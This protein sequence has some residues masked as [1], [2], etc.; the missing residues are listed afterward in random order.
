MGV[1]NGNTAIGNQAGGHISGDGNV[2]IG[3]G[4]DGVSSEDNQTWIR[5]INTTLQTFVAG[6]NNYV[7]IRMSDGRLGFTA[8]VSSKRY[9]RDIK[10]M[11]ESS[12]VIL[13]LKP[14]VFRLN[15]ELDPTGVYAVG[16]HRGRR[17]GGGA[18]FGDQ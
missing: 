4:V 13:A 15:K 6:I 11:D 10:P 12:E 18:R 9:K 5:N 8:N 7:T 3:Q 1:G 2:C 16:A 17:A 14:V